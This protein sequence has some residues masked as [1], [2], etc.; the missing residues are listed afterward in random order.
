MMDKT[1]R[2]YDTVV[3]GAGIAGLTAS[4]YLARAGKSVLLIEKNKECGGLVSSFKTDGFTFD[5][6]VRALEERLSETEEAKRVAE[7]EAAVVPEPVEEDFVVEEPEVRAEVVGG[8]AKGEKDTM[9]ESFLR[10]LGND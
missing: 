9:V 6:G 1:S 3:V 8:G 10:F 4:T 7:A 2:K 5:A